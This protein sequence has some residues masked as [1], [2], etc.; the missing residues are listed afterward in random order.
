LNKIP[1][2]YKKA[3][4]GA[5]EFHIVYSN[6]KYRGHGESQAIELLLAKLI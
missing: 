5:T 1:Y 4:I 3:N 2:F 6:T